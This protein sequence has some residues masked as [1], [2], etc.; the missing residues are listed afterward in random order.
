MTSLNVV[1]FPV[2]EYR[3]PVKMLRN[4]A[5]DIEAGIHGDITSITIVTFGE[6]M[7]VFAGGSDADAPTCALLLNAASLRFAREIE[8]HGR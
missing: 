4:I 7:E 6:T 2:P 3:N 5:D 1:D 8:G